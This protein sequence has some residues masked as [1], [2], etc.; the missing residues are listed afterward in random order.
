MLILLTAFHIILVFWLSLTD[1]QNFPGRVAFFKNFPVLENAI[2]KFQNFPGFQDPYE[3]CLSSRK[4]PSK[5]DILG[6]RLRQVPMYLFIYLEC[7]ECQIRL[8][9]D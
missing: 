8:T 6:G 7:P 9:L 1:F 2:T 3:P 4:R 5:L